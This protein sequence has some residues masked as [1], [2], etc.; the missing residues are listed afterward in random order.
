[1]TVV[2]FQTPPVSAAGWLKALRE[3]AGLTISEVATAV[4]FSGPSGWARYESADYYRKSHISVDLARKLEPLLVGRG[5]PP[6]AREEVWSLAGVIPEGVTREV[7]GHANAAMRSEPQTIPPMTVADMVAHS[8]DTL[9]GGPFVDLSDFVSDDFVSDDFGSLGAQVKWAREKAGISQSELA[10]RVGVKPQ[11]IQAIESGR[12]RATRYIV[13]I[14]AALG[15][16]P[17]TLL[18]DS[19]DELR[20]EWARITSPGYQPPGR[21][22]WQCPKCHRCLSPDEKVCTHGGEQ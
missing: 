7:P 15:V 13:H 1:M 14:A 22:G 12:V 20:S 17:S 16:K 11:S 8:E 19:M 18:M 4:G 2:P 21:L 3:R 9:A 10:R 5:N 6:I